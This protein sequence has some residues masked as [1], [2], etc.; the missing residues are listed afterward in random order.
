M[1]RADGAIV[2]GDIDRN[3]GWWGWGA[4]V[5]L[6]I[7]FWVGMTIAVLVAGALFALVGGRQLQGASAYMTEKVGRSVLTGVIV[8]F[9]IPIVGILLM[10]TVVGIPAGIGVLFFLGPALLFLGYLVAGSWLGR[11]VL[12]RAPGE[13]GTRGVTATL[14]GLVILQVVF[15][16]PG[17]GWVVFPIGGIWGTGAL[18]YYAFTASRAGAPRSTPRPMVSS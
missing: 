18:V 15:L 4:A 16:V 8:L 12:S 6:G 2:R 14:L 9:A 11:L 7:L 5:V 17:L 13:D 10:L 1:E 3:W